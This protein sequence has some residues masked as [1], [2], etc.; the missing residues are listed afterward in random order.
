MCDGPVNRP[1][2][3][4]PSRYAA[5]GSGVSC[6]QVRHELGRLWLGGCHSEHVCTRRACDQVPPAAPV[7]VLKEQ[8]PAGP[9]LLLCPHPGTG[10]LV[11][12]R[13][14]GTQSRVTVWFTHMLRGR[15][16]GGEDPM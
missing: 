11:L 6:P 13:R 8:P 7:P 12:G 14:Q 10:S 16:R 15:G 9:T 1:P 4:T 5:L 3:R 2:A